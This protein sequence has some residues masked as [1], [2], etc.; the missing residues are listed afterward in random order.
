MTVVR[1]PNSEN[2]IFMVYSHALQSEGGRHATHCKA[3]S[4]LLP[5]LLTYAAAHSTGPLS[6]VSL[7]CPP[8]PP[9]PFPGRVSF[10]PHQCD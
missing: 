9:P 2:A 4:S 10:W 6:P 7:P 8:R 5:A 3:H 1:V